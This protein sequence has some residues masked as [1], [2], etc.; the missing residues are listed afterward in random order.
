MGKTALASL[1]AA[2]SRRLRRSTLALIA[3]AGLGVV[4][5]PAS[6]SAANC[7]TNDTSGACLWHAGG[8]GTNS[9][10][11]IEQGNNE[12]NLNVSG[13]GNDWEGW[14]FLGSPH[15]WMACHGGVPIEIN[16]NSTGVLCTGVIGGTTEHVE[17]ITGGAEAVTLLFSSG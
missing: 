10:N 17:Q 4:V 11:V 1:Q 8:A 14:L 12:F 3:A 2:G 9:P 15:H 16:K 7:V 13:G 5:A 6:A